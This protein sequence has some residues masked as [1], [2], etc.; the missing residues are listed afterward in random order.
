MTRGRVFIVVALAAT[1]ACA[2]PSPTG[3]TTVD[4]GRFAPLTAP[5][6]SRFSDVLHLQSG[7]AKARKVKSGT[8]STTSTS[9]SGS[10]TLSGPRFAVSGTWGDGGSIGCQPC[11]SGPATIWTA[12]AFGGSLTGSATVDGVQY[13]RVYLTGVV[14]VSGTAMVPPSTEPTFTVTLPFTMDDASFLIGYASNP[15]IGAAQELFRIDLRGSGVGS[16][17]LSTVS[18]PGFANV[19]TAGSITYTF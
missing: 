18:I 11:A 4:A 10:L 13:E 17:E 1:A 5:T 8:M 14:K 9:M 19:Y 2:A 7:G 6:D 12:A 15:L 3:P 16:L